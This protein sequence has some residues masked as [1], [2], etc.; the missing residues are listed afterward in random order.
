[1]SSGGPIPIL[2]Q[3]FT[4]MEGL[5]HE[6]SGRLLEKAASTRWELRATYCPPSR[7]APGPEAKRPSSRPLREG[8]GDGCQAAAATSL[9]HHLGTYVFTAPGQRQ[10]HR[11]AQDRAPRG[12]AC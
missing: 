5:A 11:Q 9:R 10:A 6:V 2:R 12:R 7:I 8:S 3:L 4:D 1:M